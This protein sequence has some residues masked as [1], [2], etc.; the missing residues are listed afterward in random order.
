MYEN[1]DYEKSMDLLREQNYLSEREGALW[2]DSSKLGDEKDNVVVRSSGEPTYFAA[3]IAYHYN[4]FINRGFDSVVNIWGADHQGHVPRME[5][6]VTAIGVD[7]DRLTI[8]ISQM[9]TLKRGD[10]V[11]KMAKRAGD[12]VTLRELADVVPVR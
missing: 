4:K 8:L 7:P 6:A 10:E 9:V 11:V 2:F 1:N 12:F 5:S 3:D